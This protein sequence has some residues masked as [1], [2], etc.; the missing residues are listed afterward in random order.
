MYAFDSRSRQ[1]VRQ[2]TTGVIVARATVHDQCGEPVL[3]GMRK[4]FIRKRHHK[5]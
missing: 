3:D 1:P 2:R 5:E 4:Y